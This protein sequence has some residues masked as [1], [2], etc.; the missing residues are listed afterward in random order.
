MRC[1][2]KFRFQKVIAMTIRTYVSSFDEMRT[3]PAKTFVVAFSGGLDSSYLLHWLQQNRTDARRIA[4][5]AS[6]FGEPDPIA[7]ERAEIF[8]A[9]YV[10]LDVR[11][12]FFE[13]YAGPAVMHNAFYCGRFPISSSL[14]RPL[15]AALLARTWKQHP[16]SVIVHS[17]T[18]M[19]N[20]A[21]RLERSLAHLVPTA[22]ICAPYISS[23]MSRDDKAAALAP[24]GIATADAR[25]SVDITPVARVIENGELEDPAN[26]ISTVGIFEW[27]RD[28]D[29]TPNN[30]EPIQLV[31]S[32]GVPIA[33]GTRGLLLEEIFVELNQLGG[34]HGIGRY[35]GL[36]DTAFN[37]KNHEVRE[38]PAMAILVEAKRALENAVLTVDEFLEK[39]RIDQLWTTKV[40]EGAWFDE[41]TWAYSA[42]SS[43]LDK[44]I[45]GKVD[46][47]L[48]KGHA[49]V[50]AVHAPASLSYMTHAEAYDDVISSNGLALF[51]NTRDLPVLLRQQTTLAKR[52]SWA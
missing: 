3:L 48:H 12:E 10:P 19:Q 47:M 44:L 52:S 50:V 35:S 4:V 11:K 9:E 15:I 49:R 45:T 34:I 13:Q 16:D 8:G 14:T 21:R 28:I 23:M 42:F 32:E 6:W 7:A 30:G 33:I 43:K 25:Y 1:L 38:A 46:L 40:V 2:N 18:H 37:V 41:L 36:E 5:H 31:F 29:K 51:S 22:T 20:T 24:F 39:Q 27:T 17:A 26:P